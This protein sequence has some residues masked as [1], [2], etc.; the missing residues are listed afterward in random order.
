MVKTLETVPRS[1][2]ANSTMHFMII[3]EEFDKKIHEI[4]SFFGFV[5]SVYQPSFDN[6]PTFLDQIQNPPTIKMRTDERYHSYVN[7]KICNLHQYNCS[8]YGRK[9]LT[10]FQIKKILFLI[11]NILIY[12]LIKVFFFDMIAI[13]NN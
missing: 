12:L 5:N 4:L 8:C 2:G 11:K 3:Y 9:F 1:Y 10:K 7:L 6:L 13:K